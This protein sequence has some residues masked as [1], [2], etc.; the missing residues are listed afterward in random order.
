[1]ASLALLK[2]RACIPATAIKDQKKKKKKTTKL[3]RAL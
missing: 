2:K 1:M 3:R